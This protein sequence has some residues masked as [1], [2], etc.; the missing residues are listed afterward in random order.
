MKSANRT[1]LLALATAIVGRKRALIAPLI[2]LESP[3]LPATPASVIVRA[4]RLGRP[5]FRVKFGNG[6]DTQ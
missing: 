5:I 3:L 6:E 1:R 2:V 4:Q